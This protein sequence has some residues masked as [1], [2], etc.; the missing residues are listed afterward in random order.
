VA[1]WFKAAV[2]KT[3]M[4][5]S[6]SWVRIPP[7]P[8]GSPPTTTIA[9]AIAAGETAVTVHCQNMVA[10]FHHQAR[11]SFDELKL[12]PEMIFVHIPQHRRFACTNAAGGL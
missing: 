12:P 5:A 3:A 2:L 9:D 4:G 1:E 6:P 11:R 7:L 10:Y 8:P